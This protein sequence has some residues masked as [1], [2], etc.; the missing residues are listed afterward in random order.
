MSRIDGVKIHLR[1]I[2]LRRP[3]VTAVRTAHS[4]NALIIEV[5][6]TDG[7][8]GWGEAPTSWRVTGESIESV[9]AAVGGPLSEAIN[10]LAS[11]DPEASSAALERAVIGNSSARMAVDCAL[12]D[13]A[14]RVEGVPLY[15]YLRGN[16]NAVRTDM[17]LSAVL[18]EPDLDELLRTA[19]EHV[20]AGFHAL[21]VKVAAGGDD[22]RALVEVRQAVG[23]AIALRVDANQGWSPDQAVR[24]VTAL[25]DAGV[26]LEFV[27]QPVR[28]ED[29]D[30]LAY[31][32]SRVRTPVMADESV[33]TRRDLR[34]IVRSRAADMVNIKLAKTGGVREALALANMARANDVG[35]MVGCMSESHVGIS[36]AAALASALDQG[37][38]PESNSHDLDGG[39]WL[40]QSP[41]EGGI[42][43]SGDRV[44]LP[45]TPGTGI[46][47]VV[48]T[49]PH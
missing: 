26:G 46:V 6:D 21:K 32:T 4:V 29:I 15:R 5:C 41:V 18:S 47:G 39:L 22:L 34:E 24:I 31:V 7:R 13:L 35:V 23:H 33:W 48:P 3:F 40:T 49:A 2:A 12:Y 16:A 9:T 28:R 10:G 44:I 14:A 17:T 42:D 38:G 25:E 27:E 19:L 20:A 1:Q 30:G 45:E 43:Y 11:D 36:A 8:S 37:T